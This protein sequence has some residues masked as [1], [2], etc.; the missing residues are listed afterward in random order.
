MP[1]PLIRPDEFLSGYIGTLRQF[2]NSSSKSTAI[3]QLHKRFGSTGDKRRA[4]TDLVAQVCERSLGE[5]VTMHTLTPLSRAFAVQNC[6]LPYGDDL[7]QDRLRTIAGRYSAFYP[8]CCPAC[9]AED[10]DSLGVSYWRR[11]HLI[12]GIDYCTKHPNLEL[13]PITA[14]DSFSKEPAH[15]LETHRPG[16]MITHR[17]ENVMDNEFIRRYVRICEGLLHTKSPIGKIRAAEAMRLQAN[18]LELG[19][20]S[21]IHATKL[22]ELIQSLAPK[23]WLVHHFPKAAGHSRTSGFEKNCMPNQRHVA[24]ETIVLAA[25]ALYSSANEALKDFAKSAGKDADPNG[26]RSRLKAWTSPDVLRVYVDA[27]FNTSAVAAHFGTTKRGTARAMA[28]LGY[29][30]I[31]KSIRTKAGEALIMFLTGV[32]L[33]KAVSH[34]AEKRDEFEKMLLA[35]AAPM[36]SLFKG[37]GKPT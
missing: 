29:P 32:P 20:S 17:S 36:S 14:P 1:F 30:S 10:M 25:T 33:E 9:I 34:A 28:A 18:K 27:D 21:S 2:V 5:I 7:N 3:L 4:T 13:I 23:N 24:A 16:K 11:H 26:Q 31:H 22:P 19:L 6:D 8:Q 35:V 12:R 37:L 15:Y